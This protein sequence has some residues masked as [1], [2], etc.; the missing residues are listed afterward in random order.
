M[1]PRS[2]LLTLL[3]AL[4]AVSGLSCAPASMHSPEVLLERAKLRREGEKWDEAVR[5]L[6]EAIALAPD[7]SNLYY[8]RALTHAAAGHSEL[9]IADYD[10]ALGLRPRFP[11]AL[12]N[13]A[14]ILAQLERY[15]EA[16]QGFTR[17]IEINRNDAL[18]IRNRGL[19]Y[20]DQ[21]E[22]AKAIADLD[23]AI[24]LDPASSECWFLR[25]NACLDGDQAAEAVRSF[26]EGIR[27]NPQHAESFLNRSHAHE[28]LGQAAA[29]AKDLARAKSIDPTVDTPAEPT[30]TESVPQPVADTIG[31]APPANQ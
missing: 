17:A 22:Y 1:H 2:L 7:D 23:R 24:E 4:V 14:A 26:T 8:E 29:A 6:T 15:A 20:H 19:A 27:L 5:L 18:A 10:L 9:A 28:K 30:P 25:G 3:L 11:E 16:A 13:R 21:G 31:D 12:N